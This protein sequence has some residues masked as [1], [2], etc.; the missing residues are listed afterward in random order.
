MTTMPRLRSKAYLTCFYCGR[1]TS[2]R[3][4]GS[5]S[6]FEC[7]SCEAT[8]YL[9]EN[10]EITD[11]PLEATAPS[12]GTDDKP[13]TMGD[14]L[15]S[16]PD[17]DVFCAECLKN[18]RLF[19]AS[20]AQYLPGDP[21]DP[22]YE[23]RERNFYKFRNNL[24][25][26][27]PQT[28][29]KCE[30][31]VLERIAQAG[32]T[33]KTDH[34]RR[35][36]DRSLK[37]RTVEQASASGPLGVLAVVGRYL[38]LAGFILQGLWHLQMM[39]DLVTTADFP[40]LR[41]FGIRQLL[42]VLA[43][44]LSLLPEPERLMKSSILSTAV[45]LWW[46]P[47]FVKTVRGFTK[48]LLG[49]G[50][51]YTYQ[52]VIMLF[53]VLAPGI[54]NLSQEHG[55]TVSAQ[56]T[57]HSLTCIFIF[58][59]AKLALSSIRVDTTPLFGSKSFSTP[60][61]SEAAPQPSQKK[62]SG[63]TLFD[64]LDEVL[65]SPIP[66]RESDSETESQSLPPKIRPRYTEGPLRG[67]QMTQRGGLFVPENARGSTFGRQDEIPLRTEY[68]SE[69]DWQPTESPP[70]AFNP[71][72]APEQPL[73]SFNDAPANDKHG[74]FW[75][76]VPPAPATSMA[77]RGLNP[78]TA[79]STALLQTQPEPIQQRRF[80]AS[81]EEEA[82]K[83]QEARDERERK[84]AER[85]KYIKSPSFRYRA[86]DPRDP[87][88]DMFEDTFKISPIRA[89]PAQQAAQKAGS[90]KREVV[91]RQVKA[92]DF[93]VLILSALLL[94]PG[95]E[96]FVPKEY[97]VHMALSVCCTSLII[98]V[99]VNLETFKTLQVQGRHMSK[100][101]A[102]TVA[103]ALALSEVGFITWTGSMAQD[104][105]E[106]NA[107]VAFSSQAKTVFLSLLVIHQLW[108]LFVIPLVVHS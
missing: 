53:R 50:T 66:A 77:H 89:A 43:S 7:P 19:T 45:S 42:G 1:K 46:N 107:L 73:R 63:N 55:S 10:G 22:E 34:L 25:R 93:S 16:Q 100:A 57:M 13:P 35:M 76:K 58:Y 69:M 64:T 102:Y 41:S 48:H 91:A 24:E 20:L 47:F 40:W 65:V 72:S 78:S 2:T 75:F 15:A 104:S 103:A 94:I 39:Q 101:F 106:H 4:D 92:S 31:K 68:A 5:V 67:Q 87:L 26:Q 62:P 8:N 56:V 96:K 108:N 36:I 23:A 83:E 18:Q 60:K 17:Q 33:A 6:R 74:P 70:R 79:S 90:P 9:D 84:E 38:W 32:Y 54:P 51:W 80:F 44:L 11:P 30:P 86:N 28:C 14:L 88:S 12:G 37:A 105:G 49:I 99:R 21:D 52:A 61:S 81:R 98:W 27:Y 29:S 95:Y 71:F 85:T 97:G 59:A 3:N 82:R